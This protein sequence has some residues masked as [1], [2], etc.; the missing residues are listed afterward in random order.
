MF[1]NHPQGM[2]EPW[3][4]FKVRSDKP[5]ILDDPSL[6]GHDLRDNLKDLA[7]VNRFLGGYSVIGRGL[8]QLL[9]KYEGQELH[10]VDVGCGGGDNLIY[11][12]KLAR[13]KGWRIKFTGIDLSGPAVKLA[14]EAT[15]G[16]PE[17]YILQ[18]SVFSDEF[19]EIRADIYTLNLVLH[20]FDNQDIITLINNMSE[21]ADI[22]VSDLQR[23]R[24]AYFLFILFSRLFGFSYVSRHDGLLSVKKSFSRHDWNSLLANSG[25]NAASVT[26]S[27]AF[28]YLV[29]IQSRLKT[30]G[31]I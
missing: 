4:I 21:R 13:K 3:W 20:H 17:I 5:E 14:R 29:L 15:A 24:V 7:R 11:M 30:N 12:A 2:R 16:Y 9:S 18:A 27:W 6:S 19:K 23:N 28:R 22:L 8:N 26:W 10:L 31:S 1:T 25:I